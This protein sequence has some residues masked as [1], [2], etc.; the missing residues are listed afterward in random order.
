[1]SEAASTRLA[2]G[3]PGGVLEPAFYERLEV[4]KEILVEG[5]RFV[6]KVFGE[7]VDEEKMK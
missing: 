6:G 4:I 1:L 3:N 5:S 2:V 7:I